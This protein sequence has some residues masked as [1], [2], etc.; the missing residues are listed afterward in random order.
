MLYG[1]VISKNKTVKVTWLTGEEQGERGEGWDGSVMLYGKVISK[2]K[3]VK[4][5]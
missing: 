1:K 4:V 5:T 3:T 2:D